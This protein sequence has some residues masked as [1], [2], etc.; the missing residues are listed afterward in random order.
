MSMRMKDIQV[1][2]LTLVKPSNTSRIPHDWKPSEKCLFVTKT[3]LELPAVFFGLHTSFLKL[4]IINCDSSFL[5]K[6]VCSMRSQFHLRQVST[7]R[8]TVSEVRKRKFAFSRCA[9]FFS[10][11]LTPIIHGDTT[12]SIMWNSKVFTKV[13][14]R[15][16]ISSIRILIC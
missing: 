8:N 1:R 13:K 7:T 5:E 9:Q 10:E 6:T 14:A 3:L 15:T 2:A 11:L 12:V 4:N 16:W